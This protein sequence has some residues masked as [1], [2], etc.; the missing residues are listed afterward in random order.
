VQKHNH[1]NGEDNRDGSDDNRSANWGVEGPTDDP[2]IEA[3]RNRQVKNFF[4]TTLLSLGLPMVL[5]GDEVRRTQRGNNNA[6]TQDNEISSFDWSLLDQHADVHRFVSLLNSHRVHRPVGAEEGRLS[7]EQVLRSATKT[8]HGVRLN[9]PD[10]SDS[11]HSVAF[12][13]RD[14]SESLWIHLILNA[15][16]EP[17]H[18]ELPPVTDVNGSWRR[19]IDTSL[20]SPSDI[21]E[22]D[23]APPVAEESYP[24]GAR[25]VVVSGVAV[26]DPLAARTLVCHDPPPIF[27]RF[28]VAPCM[29]LLEQRFHV[30]GA[31]PGRYTAAATEDRQV[32]T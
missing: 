12:T 22:W 3:L 32:R 5:M 28:R 6:Y 21:V 8:W 1:D 26:A 10:W 17:L 31:A 14:P 4:A 2:G 23:A 15:Y 19:W 30:M 24:V 25:S 16:W 13:A 7:L 27:R 18:F 20:D 9:Q 11:S 29:H